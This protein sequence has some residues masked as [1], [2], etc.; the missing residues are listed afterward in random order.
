[1]A[2]D[3]NTTYTANEDH[4]KDHAWLAFQSRFTDRHSFEG[5]YASLCSDLKSE[6]LRVASFYLFLV[7]QGEWN[8]SVEGSNSV[9]DYLSNSYKLVAMFALIESLSNEKHQDFYEWLSTSPIEEAFPIQN[10]DK[11][12]ALHVTY[13]STYGSIRRCKAFFDRLPHHLQ[14]QL[15]HSIKIDG[16]PLSSITKVAEFLYELRSKF[17]H[18]SSLVLELNGRDILSARGR[19][20][21]HAKLSINLLL[22]AFEYG[23]ILYFQDQR[24]A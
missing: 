24:T 20:V 11:L 15:R 9:I 13:K 12:A 14:D 22:E 6:F 1:M 17:V 23:V 10:K 4:F 21:V 18:E 19:K 7:Q 5:F 3:T 2:T 8:V 16:N